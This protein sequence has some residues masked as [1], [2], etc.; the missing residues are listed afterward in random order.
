M[1]Y[2]VDITVLIALYN[3][4]KYI[5]ETIESLLNQTFKNFEI[6]IINDAS[7][8]NSVNVVNSINDDRI[9]LIHNETNK[10]ICLTR[11][12]GIKEAKGKYIAILDADDLAMPNRLEKQFLFLE[13]NPEIVLCGTNANFIDENNNK[14]DHIHALN[15]DPDLIKIM[16]LFVE[17]SYIILYK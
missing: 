9:R 17:N 2:T 16:L 14:I 15:C 6:L 1:K 11:Q 7:T 8:D 12:K 10:G 3:S 4:E 13:N 5:K